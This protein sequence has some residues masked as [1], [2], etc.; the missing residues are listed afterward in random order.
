[1]G[2]V[3]ASS[4]LVR[5]WTPFRP[6][7]SLPIRVPRNRALA[8]PC[9][10]RGHI[11]SPPCKACLANDVQTK[12]H[13]TCPSHSSQAATASRHPERACMPCAAALSYC[14]T[15]RVNLMRC[16]VIKGALCLACC[17][18]HRPPIYSSKPP[19]PRL[20]SISATPS[21]PSC[22]TH[23]L[24]LC[25]GPGASPE[26]RAAPRATRPPPT[27]SESCRVVAVPMSYHLVVVLPPLFIPRSIALSRGCAV[28]HG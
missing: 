19:P 21:V 1:L 14:C 16:T 8:R 17:P 9:V 2:R 15:L 5:V 11:A 23:F 13:L 25:A 18:C 4:L 7:R 24:S 6:G 3:T 26:L 10:P 20:A 28:V 12:Y 27:P 22:L